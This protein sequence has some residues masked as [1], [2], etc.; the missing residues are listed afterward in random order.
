[1]LLLLLL[2][3]SEWAIPIPLLLLQTCQ[4][5]QETKQI[6]LFNNKKISSL[7]KFQQWSQLYQRGKYYFSELAVYFTISHNFSEYVDLDSWYLT[8]QGVRGRQVSPPPADASPT[9]SSGQRSYRAASRALCQRTPVYA[10]FLPA[11]SRR[12]LQRNCNFGTLI[13]S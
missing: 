10:L 3:F 2:H 4:K 6:F 13:W 9:Y 12:G 8:A 11:S 5:F 1:M 7:Y